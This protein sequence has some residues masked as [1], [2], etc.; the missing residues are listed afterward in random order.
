[1]T[2]RMEVINVEDRRIGQILTCST[3]CH[4][5]DGLVAVEGE[6]KVLIPRKK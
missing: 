1:M 5:A 6:A 4:R 2:A 3:V